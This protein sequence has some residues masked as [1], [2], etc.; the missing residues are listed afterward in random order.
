MPLPEVIAVVSPPRSGSSCVAGLIHT[1]GVSMGRSLVRPGPM[2]PRGFYEAVPLLQ[3]CREFFPRPHFESQDTV[4]AQASALRQWAASRSDEVRIGAKQFGLCFML[5]AMEL[6]WPRMKLVIVERPPE[7][8]LQSMIASRRWTAHQARKIVA[9]TIGRRAEGLARIAAPRLTLPYEDVLNDAASAIDRLIDFCGLEPS[10]D[11]RAAAI[12][13][14]DPKLRH[15]G[16]ISNTKGSSHGAQHSASRSV[17]AA[18]SRG[19][20]G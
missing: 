19:G 20:A 13:F 18:V 2:N 17:T 12:A 7:A 10:P 8:I 9:L 14:V 11:Q 3:L 6:A 15:Y 5:P 1:L 4:K 16:G